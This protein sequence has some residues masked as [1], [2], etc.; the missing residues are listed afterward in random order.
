MQHRYLCDFKDG[1]FIVTQKGK[2]A[3]CWRS[4]ESHG[5]NALKLYVD[6][7]WNDAFMNFTDEAKVMLKL[8]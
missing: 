4:G 8:L 3:F 7:S 5:Y 2:P 1:K 6:A